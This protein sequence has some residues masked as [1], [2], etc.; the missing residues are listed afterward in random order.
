MDNLKRDRFELLSAYL[1]GEVTPAE[2]RQ[3]EEWL[4]YDAATQQ[5]YGRLLKLRQGIHT[6][7]VPV[8]REST[9]RIATQVL[10]RV[11]RRP[12]L[13]LVWGGAA[14]AAVFLGFFVN[15][16][17]VGPMATQQ[18][19]SSPLADDSGSTADSERLM[20][21]LDRPIIEIPDVAELNSVQSADLG[22][23]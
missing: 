9:D 1:D 15:L 22:T 3:V 12:K 23:P 18:I 13:T 14:I 21:A 19:A 5:L 4:R 16:P 8:S 2:R 20:I 11:E 10:N 17:A 7:S 6:L